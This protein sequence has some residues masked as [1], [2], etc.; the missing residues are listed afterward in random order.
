MSERII[1]HIGLNVADFAAMTAFYERRS[2]P[3]VSR[4]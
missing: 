1:D 3:W 4:S 2:A